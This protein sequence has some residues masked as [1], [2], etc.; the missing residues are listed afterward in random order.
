MVVAI[1][2]LES[3]RGHPHARTLTVW[4]YKMSILAVLKIF[5]CVGEVSEYDA[6]TCHVE[7]RVSAMFQ[8]GF[9]GMKPSGTYMAPVALSIT[10]CRDRIFRMA[11]NT[12]EDV[13]TLIY[14]C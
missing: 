9:S 6:F 3:S 5:H 7:S 14:V 10:H 1:M 4:T 8:E 12:V 2:F 13:F 11:G